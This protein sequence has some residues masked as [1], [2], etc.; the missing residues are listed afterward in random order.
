MNKEVFLQKFKKII[1]D[2]WELCQQKNKQYGTDDAL[3]NFRAG[4]ALSEQDLNYPGMYKVLKEY[5]LKHVAHVYNNHIGGQGVRESL[6]D[7]AVYCI[8]G[9]I[10]V[11][12]WEDIIKDHGEAV[13]DNSGEN[14]PP[15]PKKMNDLADAMLYA[16]G[17]DKAHG[18]DKSMGCILLDEDAIKK[19]DEEQFAKLCGRM[20]K[21]IKERMKHE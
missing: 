10:M 12:A 8:I 19:M 1:D 9:M 20:F 7:I 15:A 16:C 6:G 21:D 13:Q 18:K 17:C 3:A 14:Q 2:T 4:A 11:D 5:M